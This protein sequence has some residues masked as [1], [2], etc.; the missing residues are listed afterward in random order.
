MAVMRLIAVWVAAAVLA[1][2]C[3]TNTY[4]I[5]G[6]ELRRIS[7]LPPE[8]RDRVASA[9]LARWSTGGVTLVLTTGAL[10]VTLE[11]LRARLFST[12][13]RR[14]AGLDFALLLAVAGLALVVAPE[15]LYLH[16][17]FGTRMN[18]VFKFWYQAWL[19]F[20]CAAAVGIGRPRCSGTAMSWL[21]TRMSISASSSV[22]PM[23]C[24]REPIVARMSATSRSGGDEARLRAD[25]RIIVLTLPGCRSAIRIA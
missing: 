7:M 9:F 8:H 20:S 22:R 24:R 3:T 13:E 6:S 17:S 2:G 23:L 15:L 21:W 1:T 11:A 16:D 19:L 18:T 12:R 5:P 14:E 4:K 25:S 10:A